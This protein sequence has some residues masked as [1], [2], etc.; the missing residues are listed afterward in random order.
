VNLSDTEEKEFER[1][2]FESKKWL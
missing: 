1:R 2:F